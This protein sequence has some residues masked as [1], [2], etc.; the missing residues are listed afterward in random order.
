MAFEKKGPTL[1]WLALGCWALLIAAGI[2]SKRVYGH[3]D[4]MVF[5]H[6]PAAVFLVLSFYRLSE[7]VRNRY[8][9][10]QAR[11]SVHVE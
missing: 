2:V 5:F 7:N 11:R 4:W 10:G 3:A 8:R 6:L 9:Q 1:G